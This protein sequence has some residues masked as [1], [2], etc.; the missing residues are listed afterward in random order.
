VKDDLIT[1]APESAEDDPWSL[2][3]A[4]DDQKVY[5]YN[6]AHKKALEALRGM[7]P[8]PIDSLNAAEIKE[9]Y[10]RSLAEQE[11]RRVPKA[12]EDAVRQFIVEAPE[13]VL[14][15]QNTERVDQYFKAAGLNATSPDHFHQA[16]QALSA[17]C[18]LQIDESK[19]PRT[20]RKRVTQNELETMPLEQLAELANAQAKR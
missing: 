13:F 3:E 17:R 7:P 5:E 16:Y 14:S 19:R 20:P 18:L 10:E 9:L 11:Q 12:Q 2:S 15:K 6:I 4:I 1:W 8:N